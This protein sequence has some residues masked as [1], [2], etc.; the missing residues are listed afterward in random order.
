MFMR[1]NVLTSRLSVGCTGSYTKHEPNYPQQ[2]TN[3]TI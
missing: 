3:F 1:K 2:N